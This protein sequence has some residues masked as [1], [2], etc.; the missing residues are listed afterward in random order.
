MNKNWKVIMDEKT[1]EIYKDEETEE[2]CWE[3]YNSTPE[4]KGFGVVAKT[5]EKCIKGIVR[6]YK[7]ELNQLKIELKTKTKNFNKLLN[8][9]NGSD[10][11]E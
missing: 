9:L 1:F 5:R 11:N 8:I 7:K 6:H 10:E 4:H 2:T 3:F